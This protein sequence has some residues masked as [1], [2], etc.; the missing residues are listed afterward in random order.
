MALDS[1]A[2]LSRDMQGRRR[3]SESA[4]DRNLHIEYAAYFR[5]RVPEGTQAVYVT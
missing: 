3:A 2:E 5:E 1:F 4:A